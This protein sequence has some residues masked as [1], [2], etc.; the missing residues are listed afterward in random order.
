M[1]GRQTDITYANRTTVPQKHGTPVRFESCCLLERKIT[2]HYYV[3]SRAWS[4]ELELRPVGQ[5]QNLPWIS[6]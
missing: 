2:L 4:A 1:R 3:R 5:L 6:E